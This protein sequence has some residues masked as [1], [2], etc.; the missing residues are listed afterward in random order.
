MSKMTEEIKTK[1]CTICGKEKPLGEFTKSSKAKDGRGSYCKECHRKY[2]KQWT[3]DHLDQVK[4]NRKAY[5]VANADKI[6]ADR[7]V[8]K[9]EHKDYFLEYGRRYANEKPEKALLYEARKRAKEFDIP[10]TITDKDI[11]IP[12]FC[13]ILGIKLVRGATDKNRD[14]CPSLDRITPG[15]GYVVGNIAVISY[16][17][18][19]VKNNG[20]T[21]EHRRIADWMDSQTKGA[22]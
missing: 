15:N 19:R 12:E 16:R 20:T 22:A 11:V 18:N 14:C 1:V 3:A 10:F 4:E 8:Y 17:A 13:P 21:D 5:T 7:K 6:K 9:A 2:T